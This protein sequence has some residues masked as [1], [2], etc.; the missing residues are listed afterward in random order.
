[1]HCDGSEAGE[2]ERRGKSSS[3]DALLMESQ[4]NEMKGREFLRGEGTLIMM[5]MAAG[6]GGR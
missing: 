4:Q 3:D 1:M 5:M 2:D 6:A